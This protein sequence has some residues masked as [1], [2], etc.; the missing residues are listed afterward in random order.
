MF[1]EIHSI[2][3]RQTTAQKKELIEVP[4]IL[5]LYEKN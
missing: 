5:I 2:Y 1:L 4:I 3:L